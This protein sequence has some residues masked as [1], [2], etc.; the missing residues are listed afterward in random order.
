MTDVTDPLK[1]LFSATAS[2]MIMS[3]QLNQFVW[4]MKYMAVLQLQNEVLVRF[5]IVILYDLSKHIFS[6]VLRYFRTIVGEQFDN[7]KLRRDKYR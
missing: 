3:A 4:C 2:Y 6:F 1:Y 5:F 7:N